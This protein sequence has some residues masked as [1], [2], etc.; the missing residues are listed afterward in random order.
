MIYYHGY[1]NFSSSVLRCWKLGG[2]TI[3]IIIYYYIIIIIRQIQNF[4]ESL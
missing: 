1:L 4:Q 3:I 2:E